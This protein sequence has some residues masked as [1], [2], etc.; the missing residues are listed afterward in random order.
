MLP[1]KETYDKLQSIAN[2]SMEVKKS[3]LSHPDNY[4]N[5]IKIQ[6]KL[7]AELDGAVLGL[8]MI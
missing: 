3:M 6:D 2:N 7:Q 5:L 4:D 1:D 8:Y